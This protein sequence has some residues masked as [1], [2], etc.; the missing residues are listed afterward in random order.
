[1]YDYDMNK[2]LFTFI[3]AGIGTIRLVHTD[4]GGVHGFW[5]FAKK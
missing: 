2:V 4:H 5:I 3:R 1:M